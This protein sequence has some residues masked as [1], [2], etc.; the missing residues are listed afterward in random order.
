MF[1][2]PPAKQ[3]TSKIHGKTYW[4]SLAQKQETETHPQQITLTTKFRIC[5]KL[6]GEKYWMPYLSYKQLDK[7]F[8]MGFIYHN[9]TQ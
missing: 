9:V 1:K 5:Y 2:E 4:V 6:P 7:Q 3:L 8:E